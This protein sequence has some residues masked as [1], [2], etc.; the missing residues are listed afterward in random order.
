MSFGLLTIV[1]TFLNLTLLVSSLLAGLS[2]A[3]LCQGDFRVKPKALDGQSSVQRGSQVRLELRGIETNNNPVYY[4]IIQGPAWGKLSQLE[5]PDPNRQ[6]HGSVLYTH[7]DDEESRDDTFTYRVTAPISGLTSRPG[8][9]SINILDAQANFSGPTRM[10]F[11]AIVGE[12]A[13]RMLPITNQGGG[14]LRGEINV[15][16][17]FFTDEGNQFT[18]TRGQSTK[19]PIRFTPT[20]TGPVPPQK[21]QPDPS[22]PSVTIALLGQATAPFAAETSQNELELK[23]DDSRET[24]IVLTNFSTFPQGIKIRLLPRIATVSEAMVE[25]A[26]GATKMIFFRIPPEKKSGAEQ[27]RAIFSTKTYQAE[28]SFRVPAVP[29]RLRMLTPAVYFGKNQETEV[30]VANTGG[31]AGRFSVT[32]PEGVRVLEGARTFEVLAGEQ[33]KV[34][35]RLDNGEKINQFSKLLIE[36]TNADP[37]HLPVQRIPS[38]PSKA[39]AQPQD[40]PRPGLDSQPWELNKDILFRQEGNDL[41]IVWSRT[42]PGWG[43]A[44]LEFLDGEAGNWQAASAPEK[45]ISPPKDASSFLAQFSRF[46]KSADQPNPNEKVINSDP[47]IPEASWR[48][49]DIAPRLNHTTWRLSAQRIGTEKFEPATIGFRLDTAKKVLREATSSVT[50]LPLQSASAG[51]TD[52]SDFFLSERTKLTATSIEAEQTR[53]TAQLTIVAPPQITSYRLERGAIVAELNPSTGIPQTPRFQP[54][55]HEGKVEILKVTTATFAEGNRTTITASVEGLPAGRGTYWRLV[56]LSQG[57]DL[58]PTREFLITTQPPSQLLW[59]DVLFWLL[60][61]LLVG[62]FYARWRLKQTPSR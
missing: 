2:P 52:Q 51:K 3:G 18:L 33:T 36:P 28:Q 29:A 31:V 35:L 17:P 45:V 44:K 37:I 60:C 39:M 54:I 15:G 23:A 58:P 47:K 53:A 16:P 14:T 22:N 12:S 8:T 19:I 24:S 41:R 30:E 56:P 55:N 59:G 40:I 49:Q 6:G 21:I 61:S 25:L 13:V 7:G 20:E 10:D 34:R 11:A 32:P 1:P 38:V 9:L 5:Q 62:I 27:F 46:F 4:E 42:Q 57:K 43:E 50:E 26:P 48:Q